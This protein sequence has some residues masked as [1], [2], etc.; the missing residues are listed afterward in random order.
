M[1]KSLED[2]FNKLAGK[3]ILQE[4]KD[5]EKAKKDELIK[6]KQN[7]EAEERMQ[8]KLLG[9]FEAVA[10]GTAAV[11]IEAKTAVRIIVDCALRSKSNPSV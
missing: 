8:S 3:D 11:P 7:A 1:S 4:M 2:F 10:P 5:E 6:D 9:M